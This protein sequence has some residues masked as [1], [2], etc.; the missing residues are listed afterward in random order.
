MGPD[1]V[2]LVS[3]S[4]ERFGHRRMQRGDGM[5]TRRDDT[6]TSSHLDLGLLTSST[7]RK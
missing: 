5:K 1:P 2:G 7:V 4:E 3:L 6:S